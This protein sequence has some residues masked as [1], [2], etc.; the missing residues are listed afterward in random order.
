MNRILF[1]FGILFVYACNKTE[2]PSAPPTPTNP[3]VT[4]PTIP[5]ACPIVSI[6]EINK[7]IDFI[8]FAIDFEYF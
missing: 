2:V 7:K 4:I 1:A 5:V 6:S 8:N 3:V